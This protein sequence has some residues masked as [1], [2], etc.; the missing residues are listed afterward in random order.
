ML[1]PDAPVREFSLPQF[2]PEGHR[3]WL[4]RG[5]IGEFLEMDRLRV[6]GLVMN[7]FDAERPLEARFQITSSEAFIDPMA[8]NA[9]GPGFLQLLA[10][11]GS[12]RLIGREWEWRAAGGVLEVRDDV[13]VTFAQEL[14][15]ILV[16]E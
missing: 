9:R 13:R 4:L 11:D 3:E 2:A 7:V 16:I 1:M 15:P 14:G 8:R 5:R 12:F 6:E 10:P